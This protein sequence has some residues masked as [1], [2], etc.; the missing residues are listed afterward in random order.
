MVR[1]SHVAQ[2]ALPADKLSVPPLHSVCCP[3]CYKK[4]SASQLEHVAFAR[5]QYI[6]A[7]SAK[8]TFPSAKRIAT[9]QKTQAYLPASRFS[10]YLFYTYQSRSADIAS[11]CRYS[12]QEFSCG[13]QCRKLA[14]RCKFAPSNPKSSRYECRGF[15]KIS[16]PTHVSSSCTNCSQRVG[17]WVRQCNRSR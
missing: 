6:S 14:S 2:N 17:S 12:V 5:N 3:T 9:R 10:T 7:I 8:L 13:H 16:N 4:P 11:M 15:T 1:P